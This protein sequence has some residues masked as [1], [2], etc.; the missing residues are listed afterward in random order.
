[1]SLLE[2]YEE[3]FVIY[4]DFFMKRTAAAVRIQQNWRRFIS[5]K[6]QK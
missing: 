6:K 2:N 5:N 1:M 4:A 3:P